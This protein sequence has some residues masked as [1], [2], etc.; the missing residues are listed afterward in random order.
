MAN[1]KAINDLLYTDNGDFWVGSNGDLEETKN[2]LYKG[3]IQKIRTRLESNPGDWKLQ[4]GIGAG[5]Q[6]FRGREN[7]RNLGD[8]IKTVVANE[9]LQIGFLSPNEF[10]VDVIPTSTTS[11]M[12][13]IAIKTPRDNGQIILPVTYDMRENKIIPR[14]V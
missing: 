8:E 2:Y 12:I 14:A 5:L 4:P 6:G 1:P 7:T 10:V 9:I 13:I 11:I 3:L